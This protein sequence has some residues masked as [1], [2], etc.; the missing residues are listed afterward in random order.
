MKISNCFN[1]L[2]NFKE[3]FFLQK[4]FFILCFLLISSSQ[5]S[6][7]EN[8]QS[9]IFYH[10]AS[11][12]QAWTYNGDETYTSTGLNGGSGLRVYQELNEGEQVLVTFKIS[13]PH[14]SGRLY[15]RVDGQRVYLEHGKKEFSHLFKVISKK[16]RDLRVGAGSYSSKGI[17]LSDIKFTLISDSEKNN[18]EPIADA[19]K[20]QI[21]NS[22]DLVFL[23]ANE[24]HDENINSLKYQWIVLNDP[25]N[26]IELENSNTISPQF[27]APNL[28]IAKSFDIE[29]VVTDEYGLTNTDIVKI[30]ILPIENDD[31]TIRN[32]YTHPASYDKA[33]SYDG[34]ESYISTGLNGD[35]GLRVFE[36]V[37]KQEQ[38]LVKFKISEIYSSGNLSARVDSQK[39]YL[40]P[41]ELEFVHLFN[42]NSDKSN[43]LRIGVGEFPNV[44]IK[45]Y[46]IEFLLISNN[47]KEDDNTNPI[48][49][50][51]SAKTVTGGDLVTLD[52]TGSG[53][54]ESEV[55]Y[56]WTQVN[57]TD[58]EINF[59]DIN[60]VTPSF[61]A[62]SIPVKQ[63]IDFT[64]K[65]T[66]TEGLSAIDTVSMVI[67]PGFSQ[68]YKPSDD[69]RIIYVSSL[70]GNDESGLA[71]SASQVVNPTYPDEVIYPFK[72]LSAAIKQLRDGY[73]DWILLRKGDIWTNE[74]FGVFTL[75]GRNENEP[76]LIGNYGTSGMRPLVKTGREGALNTAGKKTSNLSIVGIDFYAHSRD[77]NS[78]D[79]IDAEQ[80]GSGI[81]IVGSGENIVIEDTVVRFYGTNVNISNYNGNHKNVQIKRSIVLDSYGYKDIT[82]SNGMYIAGVDGLLIEDNFFDHNGWNEDIEAASSTVFNHNVYI[83]W[84]NIAKN[85]IVRNNI[86]TRSS[87]H[88]IK[89]RPGG[90]YENNLLIE[91]AIGF[92]FGYNEKYPIAEG[93]IAI[94]YNNVV[95]SGKQRDG[96][97]AI[98]GIEVDKNALDNGGSVLLE[99]N[100]IA[101]A[102][103]ESQS[104]QA[105]I[106]QAG[107]IANENIIYDW[108]DR[109]DMFDPEWNN[110]E[111]NINSYM[112]SIGEKPTLNEFLNQLR[113]R[114]FNSWNDALTTTS[115]NNYIR[116][117]YNK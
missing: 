70:D 79:F 60:S 23:S 73:P 114:N 7:N 68:N 115:V 39:A 78:P 94:A 8:L 34:N 85:I 90:L 29:L 54:S 97:K 84:D 93:D 71:V 100:I 20:V 46:D 86:S 3:V 44:G 99:N 56:E 87:N 105:I 42:I 37:K 117:G 22:E 76:M 64:L 82:H 51:G 13:E 108:V 66:D 49:D 16:T 91:N 5:A 75:S 55:T 11:E 30:V 25:L 83:Q 6:S 113:Y 28:I 88:G 62:P 9:N 26:E 33:W 111:V 110:P 81:R 89:G 38:V 35:S 48:A 2:T 31:V 36:N 80:A 58:I 45:L 17:V 109:E 14:S 72:T 98:W 18:A 67:Q 27:Y 112:A 101:H 69:S 21:A 12:D 96:S 104:M 15:A 102:S 65:V 92:E 43:D 107:V 19:G 24:S 77:P 74:S 47:T 95:L 103:D 40:T 57:N 10:P 1:K 50:A 52:G 53:D 61:I 63:E 4:I 32:I 59:D 116:S 106:M 41:G